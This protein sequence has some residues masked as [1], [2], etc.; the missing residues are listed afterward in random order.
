MYAVHA[1]RC[2][3]LQWLFDRASDGL[4]KQSNISA[5]TFWKGYFD[6]ADKRIYLDLQVSKWYTNA[7]EKLQR[8]DNEITRKLIWKQ[9]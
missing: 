1:V 6:I 5:V 4:C 9:H 2:I 7:L 3:E 8:N